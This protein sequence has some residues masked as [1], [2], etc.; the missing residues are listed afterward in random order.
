MP[1]LRIVDGAAPGALA[2]LPPPD[3]IFI[4]G[5]VA[6]PGML[7][8]AWAALAPGGR[9]VANVVTVEG[10]ARLGDCQARHGGE[11]ARIAISRAE[12]LGGRLG[13]RPLMP[14]TQLAAS[15]PDADR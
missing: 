7:E 12:P 9:L 10:E 8:Q 4:G 5:G 6:D 13:W 3:A 11:L 2:G 1:E 14:V 15:K